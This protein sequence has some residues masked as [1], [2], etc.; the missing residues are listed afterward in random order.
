MSSR[1]CP[2]VFLHIGLKFTFDREE[3]FVEMCIL[4]SLIILG[5]CVRGAKMEKNEVI[6]HMRPFL[7]CDSSCNPIL[8]GY[9]VQFFMSAWDIPQSL[10][11]A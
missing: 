11:N 3:L 5:P 10:N 8:N 6:N 4:L 1:R 2:K 9:R 7:G